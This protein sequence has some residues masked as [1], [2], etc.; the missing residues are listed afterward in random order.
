MFYNINKYFYFI[1]R[2]PTYCASLPDVIRDEEF[3]CHRKDSFGLVVHGLWPQTSRASSVRDQPRNCRN[4]QQLPFSIIKRFYC[5]M[6]DE[7]LMQAE[8]EKHGN[9][10]HLSVFISKKNPLL[11]VHVIM[12]QQQ[13]ILQQ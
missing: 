7:D 10:I 2:S 4:E 13:I 6:P 3:Q 8:W 12:R 5:L 11:Q 9:I 1:F